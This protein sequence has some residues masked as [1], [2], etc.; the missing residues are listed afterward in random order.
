MSSVAAILTTNARYE[1]S[2]QAKR[3]ARNLAMFDRQLRSGVSARVI[4]AKSERRQRR[5]CLRH[6]EVSNRALLGLRARW[7]L[8]NAGKPRAADR[9]RNIFAKTRTLQGTALGRLEAARGFPFCE[10]GLRR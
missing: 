5:V 7:V 2:A 10:K 1:A 6:R 4:A 3:A 9:C 8:G